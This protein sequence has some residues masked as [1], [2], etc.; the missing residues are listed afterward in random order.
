MLNKE[1]LDTPERCC[2][3]AAFRRCVADLAYENCG[4]DAIEVV[5]KAIAQTQSAL[6]ADCSDASLLNPVCIWFVYFPYVVVGG[7]I[8]ALILVGCCLGACC[9]R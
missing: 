4:S 2:Y 7:I 5:D 3:F 9:C 6:Q 1:G 8:A